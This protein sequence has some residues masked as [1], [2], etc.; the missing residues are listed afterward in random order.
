MNRGTRIELIKNIAAALSDFDWTVI[1]L[2]LSEFNLPV[3]DRWD[4]EKYEY[5]IQMVQR[6]GDRT[7]TELND[8]LH[9]TALASPSDEP[10]STRGLYAFLSHVGAHRRLAS[11]LKQALA[12]FGIEAFVAHD[13]I[14]PSKE[15]QAVIRAGLS[16]CHAFIALLTDGF[17]A[18][19]WC[20]QEVGLVLARDVPVVPI[21]VDLQP[22]G[23]L[24]AFQSLD[25]RSL[26]RFDPRTDFAIAST[27]AEQIA[28]SLLKDPRTGSVLTDRMVDALAASS[29]FRV[30][31]MLARRLAESAP[32]ITPQQLH[33]LRQAE[34]QNDQV[35]RAFD[36]PRSLAAMEIKFG[37][38]ATPD[39]PPAPPTPSS[40]FAE[41][42]EPF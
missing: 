3:S 30:S 12:E 9:G 42:E 31:N 38:K 23:F 11:T 22:Y 8:Y 24:G 21:S 6:G 5:C 16:S 1:D 35:M 17:K 36:V 2:A 29:C 40:R 39:T 41:D 20:D 15:W 34:Q 25:G 37:I 19:D 10:W 4:G 13:D 18:S 33:R 28:C 27:I 14:D 32:L 7:L 26:K